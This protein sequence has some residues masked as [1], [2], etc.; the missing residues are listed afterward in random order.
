[1]ILGVGQ[2]LVLAS[3]KSALNDS[4]LLLAV[5]SFEGST[6]EY[7]LYYLI[8]LF[9]R[10]SQNIIKKVNESRADFDI[11]SVFWVWLERER[12]TEESA[13]PTHCWLFFWP[14]EVVIG[15]RVNGRVFLIIP[16]ICVC[17]LQCGWLKFAWKWTIGHPPLTDCPVHSLHN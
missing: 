15:V 10:K 3:D 4:L 17:W 13:E 2:C 6:S 11:F 8:F 7:L 14:F 16:C 12:V 9:S 5:C 1:M